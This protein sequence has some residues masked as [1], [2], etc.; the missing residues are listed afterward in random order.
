[1]YTEC[2]LTLFRANDFLT[3]QMQTNHN[4][5]DYSKYADAIKPRLTPQ[6]IYGK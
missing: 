6:S 5:W 1:M 3:P 2:H 4:L